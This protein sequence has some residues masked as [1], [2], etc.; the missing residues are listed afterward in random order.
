MFLKSN[1][2]FVL[3]MEVLFKSNVD[4]LLTERFGCKLIATLKNQIY[5]GE[6][7]TLICLSFSDLL[8]SNRLTHTVL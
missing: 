6:N 4:K 3:T 1:S 5:A 2:G 8:I 7:R